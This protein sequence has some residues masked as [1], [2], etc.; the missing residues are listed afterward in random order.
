MYD[1]AGEGDTASRVPA[2]AHMVDVGVWLGVVDG[3][4]GA[5]ATPRREAPAG[6][7]KM[8]HGI[9]SGLVEFQRYV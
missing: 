4:I 9:P 8:G 1:C 5:R 2:V 7:A 6:A 3:W